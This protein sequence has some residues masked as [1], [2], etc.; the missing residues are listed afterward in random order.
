[1]TAPCSP[2]A[3]PASAGPASTPWLRL[4]PA[5]AIGLLIGLALAGMAAPALAQSLSLN[6]GDESGSNTGRIIQFLG[7]MTILSIAPSIMIMA[8]SFVRIVIVLSFLRQA[9]GTQQI[10]PNQVMISLAMFLTFFI[11]TP[12]FKEAYENGIKPL[13]NEDIDELTAF[14]RT[15]QPFKVFMLKH[16]RERDLDLF[17]QISKT[18]P[19]ASPTDVPLQVLLPSFMLSELK[20]AFEIGFLVFIPFLVIDIVVSSLLLA[21]GMMMLPPTTVAMPFKIIFFVLID[22]WYLIV[23]SLVQSFG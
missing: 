3:T 5:L 4:L 21:M 22:G 23:G 12:V 6:L 9:L 14:D 10:P 15:V 11:M 1:M 17:M 19:V 2:A 20:R 7:L 16:T 8:T 13:V 18:P